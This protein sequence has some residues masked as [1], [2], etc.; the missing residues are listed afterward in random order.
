MYKLKLSER[1]KND[2]LRWGYITTI[3]ALD[4]QI[5]C[6]SSTVSQPVVTETLVPN[7]NISLIALNI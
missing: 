4:H 5:K 6:K 7:E 2:S 3:T 1:Y